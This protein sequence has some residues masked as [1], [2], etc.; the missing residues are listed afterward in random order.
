MLLKIGMMR[1]D[2]SQSE[3]TPNV[4]P[5]ALTRFL[6]RADGEQ[7]HQVQHGLSPEAISEAAAQ[8]RI[9][10]NGKTQREAGQFCSQHRH[11]GRGIGEVGVKVPGP[12]PP[13]EPGRIRRHRKKP[14]AAAAVPPGFRRQDPITAQAIQIA[15]RG[16]EYEEKMRPPK[17]RVGRSEQDFHLPGQFRGF[18]MAGPFLLGEETGDSYPGTQGR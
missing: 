7:Y 12:G 13:Q 1:V 17:D 11:T 15:S 18:G 5:R 10:M 6:P 14:Q 16:P 2:L 9:G 8:A 3:D 4:S